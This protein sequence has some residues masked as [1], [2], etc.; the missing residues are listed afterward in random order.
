MSVHDGHPFLFL[1][2]GMDTL[3]HS[4]LAAHTE[5]AVEM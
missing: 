2:S 3:S 5:C 4:T 1:L